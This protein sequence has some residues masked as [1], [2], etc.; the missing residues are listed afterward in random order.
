M[1]SLYDGTIYEAVKSV[2]DTLSKKV[3]E[4]EKTENIKNKRMPNEL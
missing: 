3:V 4:E 1:T 2:F